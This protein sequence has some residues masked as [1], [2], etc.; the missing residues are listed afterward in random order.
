VRD[1]ACEESFVTG[2]STS[3][4]ESNR[5][6]EANYFKSLPIAGLR[7]LHVA[8]GPCITPRFDDCLAV[9]DVRLA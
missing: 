4:L 6:A 8:C 1:D 5:L 9:A 7:V 2:R 3:I